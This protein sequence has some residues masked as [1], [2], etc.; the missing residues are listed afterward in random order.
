M[1]L[2]ASLLRRSS[3]AVAQSKSSSSSS[4]MT[5]QQQQQQQHT[6][7]KVMRASNAQRTEARAHQ[8]AVWAEDQADRLWD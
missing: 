4:S 7:N 2:S 1:C 8:R 6:H 5:Q 3:R